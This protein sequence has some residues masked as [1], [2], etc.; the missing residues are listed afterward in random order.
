LLRTDARKMTAQWLALSGNWG[1][2]LADEVGLGKTIE[3][4]ILEGHVSHAMAAGRGL[5]G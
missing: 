2:I 3:A 1:G 5:R 4:G